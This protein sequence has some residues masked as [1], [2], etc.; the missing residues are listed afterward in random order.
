MIYIYASRTGN[1]AS[2]IAKLGLDAT[3]ISDGNEKVTKD[4]VLFTYTDG[5]GDIPAEV[6][7]FLQNNGTHI[8]GVVCSGDPSYGDAFC[9]AGERISQIY[10]VS[11]LR[12]VEMDGTDEDVQAIKAS[13]EKVNQ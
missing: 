10:S 1:V 11:L 13:L 9:G 4:Y 3:Q 2:L 7:A 5:Y 8:K 6:D 12:K